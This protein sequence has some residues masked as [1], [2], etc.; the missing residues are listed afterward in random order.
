[1]C[2]F[3]LADRSIKLIIE[4]KNKMNS[5][6]L[7][8]RRSF[9]QTELVSISTKAVKGTTL[10]W[11]LRHPKVPFLRTAHKII[12]A[13]GNEKKPIKPPRRIEKERKK[14]YV[15]GSILAVKDLREKS[16]PN[17]SFWS[18]WASRV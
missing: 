5:A 13:F 15:V 16:N 9:H 6:N 18:C 1:M 17:M 10:A 7:N 12:Q 3:H 11:Q 2:Q 14:T 8:S 4:N